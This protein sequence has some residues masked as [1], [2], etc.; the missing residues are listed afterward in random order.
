MPELGEF[1]FDRLRSEARR[2]VVEP[3]PSAVSAEGLGEA[4]DGWARAVATRV[5]LGRAN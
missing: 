2:E 1:D 5:G 3:A 4:A